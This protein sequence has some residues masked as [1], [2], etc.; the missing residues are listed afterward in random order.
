MQQTIQII[1]G[2]PGELSK[3]SLMIMYSKCYIFVDYKIH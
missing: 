1:V 2:P 3:Y